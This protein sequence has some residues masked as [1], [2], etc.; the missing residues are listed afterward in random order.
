MNKFT[1]YVIYHSHIDIGYTERQERIADYHADF[2]KQAVEKVLNNDDF[3]YTAEGFWSVEQ[4]LR[5]YK[6]KGKKQLIDAVQTKRF[7][8]TAGYLHF[9][10]L[11]K[12]DNLVHSLSYASNFVEEHNLPPI[13]VAMACDIN[14]FSYGFAQA[15]FD[16]GVRYLYTNINTHHGG[17]PFSKPLVPFYWETHNG[18]KLLVWN[19][20]TYH[21]CNLLGLIPGL[22]P[23]GDAG[24]PG[25]EPT[26]AGFVEVNH[27]DDYAKERIYSMVKGFKDLGY[28]YDF[29]PISGSGI[30]TDNSPIGDEHVELIK[31]WN[32]L[33]GEEIEIKLVTL[34]EFF[35]HL[36]EVPNIQTHRG[37]WN[38]WWS[39]GVI[40][41]PDETRLYRNAQRN[42]Q[43]IKKLDPDFR[44]VN[45]QSYEHL[46]NLLILYAEHTWGHSASWSDPYKLL[47]KAIRFKKGKACYRG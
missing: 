33:Y 35:N 4:F 36:K 24:V 27:P 46:T 26:E 32:S 25:L 19:G 6:D 14:G 3:K 45:P 15:L 41:T 16:K 37:D 1:L 42:Q 20:L 22:T 2:T 5:K 30:Y 44:I 9:A 31:T 34:N 8:L 23:K 47:V 11:L 18:D 43:S 40:S 13:D 7:E 10:E 28:T 38:D 12:Y 39:D 17:A 21:K 29:A